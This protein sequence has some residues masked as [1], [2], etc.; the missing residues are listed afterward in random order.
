M[1]MNDWLSLAVLRSPAH[2]AVEF[3]GR[4]LSYQEL[5]ARVT[6]AAG[7]L[8]SIGGN[9]GMRIGLYARPAID[10]VVMIFAVIRLK[11]VLVPL[12]LRLTAEE[13]QYQAEFTQ[14]LIVDDNQALFDKSVCFFVNDYAKYKNIE[15]IPQTQSSEDDVLA[16]LFTSGTSGKPKLAQLTY[17]N[18]YYSAIASEQLNGANQADRWLCCLPLY[19][20]GALAL[21]TRA[22]IYGMTVILH[23][24]FNTEAVNHALDH[25]TVTHVSL[26]PTMLFRLI[27][28]RQ[29]PPPHLKLCLL[30]GAAATPELIEQANTLNIP[31]AT[32]YGLTEA[33]SQV[34]TLSPAYTTAKPASVGKAAKS[35]SQVWIEDESGKRLPE[36]EIG[37]IVVQGK[38]IMR[39]YFNDTDATHRTIRDGALYTGDLGYLDSDGD[40]WLIQRRSDLIVTG[41]ENV[42]P[43]EVEAA[44]RKHPQ[45][46]DACVVGIPH[47][48]WGQQ[49]AALITPADYTD[50][51]E[52]AGFL[53][54]SLAGYKI[55]R[56][57]AFAEKLP[58]LGNGKIARKEVAALLIDYA[59]K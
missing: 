18:F 42:Y 3:S 11:A 31:V 44:L 53:R 26:V 6:L 34:A 37:E 54:K 29:T 4:S 40:L 9:E 52:I 41:G 35:I 12:N 56:I 43:A 39:G 30:G 21:L 19:H 27:Q 10:T 14:I 36:G 16:M 22:V 57:M 13:L 33:C 2:P 55:P 23:D 45:I 28:A 46:H 50:R 49:V 15:A 7:W 25:N 51:S 48:E 38:T 1:S 59:K 24:G 58:L 32:T 47:P 17:G 5:D 20:V 8:R